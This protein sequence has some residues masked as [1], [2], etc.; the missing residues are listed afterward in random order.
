MQGLAATEKSLSEDDQITEGRLEGGGGGGQRQVTR[1][2]KM[3]AR[4][5]SLKG[6]I[7]RESTKK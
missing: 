5:K 4:K 1:E 3:V 7:R 6:I 2:E